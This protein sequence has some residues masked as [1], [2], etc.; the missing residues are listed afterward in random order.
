MYGDDRDTVYKTDYRDNEGT[1][2]L[3]N[4]MSHD[5]QQ[6][7]D[8]AGRE[9]SDEELDQFDARS[10]GQRNRHI[11]ISPD[12]RHGLS[13]QEMDRATRAYMS[14]MVEDRPTADY[15]YAIHDDKEDEQDIHIAM[16]AS[17]KTDL[18]M[19]PD[20]IREE[21]QRAH[22]RYQEQQKEQQQ[23]KEQEQEQQI[24]HWKRQ[25]RENEQEIERGM[26]R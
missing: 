10:E 22:S 20:D 5:Q 23:E 8:R 9:M 24:P 15:V 1:G 13:E 14:E 25:E 19:Y 12:N 2:A 4:Y 11:I 16:T 7:R 17:D 3:T 18:E 26:G 21:R 6:I